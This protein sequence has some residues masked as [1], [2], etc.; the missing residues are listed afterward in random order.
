MWLQLSFDF[1]TVFKTLDLETKLVKFK[2]HMQTEM[3]VFTEALLDGNVET[4][5][6]IFQWKPLSFLN[7]ELTTWLFVTIAGSQIK[8]KHN[9]SLNTWAPWL[10]LYTKYWRDNN[11]CTSSLPGSIMEMCHPWCHSLSAFLSIKY[12]NTHA[13]GEK[14]LNAASHRS[15]SN[16]GRSCWMDFTVKVINIVHM[17][18]KLS[19]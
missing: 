16:L 19:G 15:L 10:S 7:L 18:T 1:Y 17:V 14:R 11:A 3:E 6:T 9:N 13:E 2:H 12:L 8:C 4:C 5:L